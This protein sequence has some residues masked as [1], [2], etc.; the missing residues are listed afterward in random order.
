MVMVFIS[1]FV[2]QTNQVHA[3]SSP[4]SFYLHLLLQ[5]LAV[6][7]LIPSTKTKTQLFFL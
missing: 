5:N 6:L 2:H 1:L 3:F 7:Y 4:Y